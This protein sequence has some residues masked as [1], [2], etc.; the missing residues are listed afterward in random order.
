MRPLRLFF[1]WHLWG[2]AGWDMRHPG[3]WQGPW[4]EVTRE[5]RQVSQ[6]GELRGITPGCWVHHMQVLPL[7]LFFLWTL[8]ISDAESTILS[9]KVKRH[10]PPAPDKAEHRAC[11]LLGTISPNPPP[12]QRAGA[13]LIIPFSKGNR[14][15][16]M[17]LPL[18]PRSHS[19]LEK[20]QDSNP[21][22]A[23]DEAHALP[24]CTV[25]V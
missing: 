11:P 17:R 13:T 12:A 24:H 6:G 7:F 16:K 20:N 19:H 2:G 23:E 3:W 1:S 4:S 14:L 15:R 10:W 5:G 18:C 9:H 25:P 8:I 22:L 21:E